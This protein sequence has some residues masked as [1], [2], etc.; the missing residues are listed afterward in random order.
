MA[1]GAS[2]RPEDRRVLDRAVS[3]AKTDEAHCP[4]APQQ[5]D[6]AGQDGEFLAGLARAF[7]GAVIFALPMLMTM[8]L[9]S[10]GVYVTPSR[11]IVLVFMMIPLL[12]GLSMVS[13]FKTTRSLPGNI[14]DAF[15]AIAVATAMSTV[16]LLLFGVVTPDTPTS[17]AIGRIAL[18]V[19]PAS[20]GAMLARSQMS[21]GGGGR[22]GQP[23]SYGRELSI[24]A[25]GALFLG[26]GIAPT[27]EVMLLS[28]MMRTG[29]E[30]ML[31]L[32]SLALMH[33]FVYSVGFSSAAMRRPAA[34]FWSVFLRF[35]VVGYAIVL[36]VSCYLLWVF[37]QT[38]DTALQAVV[39]PVIVLGFPCAIGAAA[40]RLI[41]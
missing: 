12:T 33:A 19:I 21:G 32:L 26:V 8:E 10:M 41:L 16:V 4:E 31:A 1:T 27:E 30:I 25:V 34:T 38:N 24:M 22:S 39:S 5:R 9:W 15:V 14:L 40:A 35:T 23:E 29:H 18:Q 7:A 13:G 6:R 3:A 28:Y 17:E 37:G 11:L 20:I 2:A 36:L